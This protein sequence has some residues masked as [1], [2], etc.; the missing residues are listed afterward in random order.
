MLEKIINY[1]KLRD[2][3]LPKK[4]IELISKHINFRTLKK[5]E[6]F[7]KEGDN[8]S[9]IAYVS[10]GCLRVFIKD[11]K[12]IEY[13][14]YFAFEDWWVG[15]FHYILNNSPAKTSIQAIEQTELIEIS[16]QGYKPF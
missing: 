15:E 2:L 9:S 12:K 8:N 10:R 5:K 1:Y 16:S 3:N 4:E 7:F 11:H 6:F 14:R 13:N